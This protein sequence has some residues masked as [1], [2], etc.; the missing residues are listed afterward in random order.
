MTPGD[1]ITIQYNKTQY[2]LLVIET[3]P[4]NG[5][6]S[7]VETDLEVDFATPLGYVEPDYKALKQVPLKHLL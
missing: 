2:S 1:L 7:I 4:R 6:I 5:G 3:K